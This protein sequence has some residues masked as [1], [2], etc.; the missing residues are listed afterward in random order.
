M[1]TCTLQCMQVVMNSLNSPVLIMNVCFCLQDAPLEKSTDVKDILPKNPQPNPPT[2]RFH[3]A[4]LAPRP[5]DPPVI[6]HELERV[7][8]K[9]IRQPWWDMKSTLREKVSHEYSL[10]KKQPEPVQSK[11]E[12]HIR[13]TRIHYRDD[14]RTAVPKV[15]VNPFCMLKVLYRYMYMYTCRCVTVINISSA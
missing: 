10:V 11:E 9:P 12:R 5:L 3:Y 15:S 13:D 8:Y 7:E 1:Y 4:D 14:G 6:S 2:G